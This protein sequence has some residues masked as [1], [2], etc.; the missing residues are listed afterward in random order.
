MS[1]LPRCSS[2]RHIPAHQE[3]HTLACR[4]RDGL[5]LMH[6][7]LARING[8]IAIHILHDVQVT[9]HK[10][11]SRHS[12]NSQLHGRSDIPPVGQQMGKHK[13]AARSEDRILIGGQLQRFLWRHGRRHGIGADSRPKPCGC[14][15]ITA[16]RHVANHR[17]CRHRSRHGG[18]P[19][20]PCQEQGH[21]QKT[22]QQTNHGQELRRK[23]R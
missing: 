6:L 23:M 16:R 21:Q 5:A 18:M 10:S 7:R 12:R 11:A 13:M 19:P 2:S 8:A 1:S 20:V 4:Q 14:I 15:D 22:A 3:H 9:R 17:A